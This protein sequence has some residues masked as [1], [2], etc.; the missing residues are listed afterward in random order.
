MFGGQLQRSRTRLLDHLPPLNRILVLGDGDGRFLGEL[1]ER[2]PAC[3]VT[4][5]EQSAA[6]LDLQR[7]RCLDAGVSERVEFVRQDA[8]QLDLS[9]RSHDALAAL[10]FLD[11]F[12]GDELRKLLPQWLSLVRPGGWFLCVD[13]QYPAAGWK[14]LRAAVYLQLMH[15]FFRWQTAL[16]NRTLV[17]FDSILDRLP[18]T[19]AA[20]HLSSHGLIRARLYRT[21]AD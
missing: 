6:M 18:I 9:E 1:C 15:A 20:D 7:K 17:D 3:K 19:L 10:F 8:R 16:P 12:Q 13:F 11:C 4:S 5:V 2:Q 21:K 14:R